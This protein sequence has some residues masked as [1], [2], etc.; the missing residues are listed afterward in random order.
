[1]QKHT[2]VTYDANNLLSLQLLEFFGAGTACIVCPVQR[3]S[4]LGKDYHIPTVEQPDPLCVRLLNEL[5]AIYYGRISHD[6][7]VLVD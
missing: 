6:W 1:M 2:S 3:I 4:Y 5:S 7:A